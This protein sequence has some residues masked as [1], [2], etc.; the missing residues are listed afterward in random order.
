MILGEAQRIAASVSGCSRLERDSK[1]CLPEEVPCILFN[2]EREATFEDRQCD[3][4][5]R[6]VLPGYYAWT[7][8]EARLGKKK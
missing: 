1:D 4:F 2:V 3:Y 7:R 8:V 5:E 6:V